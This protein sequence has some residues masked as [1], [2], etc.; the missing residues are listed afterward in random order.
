MTQ[1]RVFIGTYTET[2]PHVAG[3]ASGIHT[4]TY[5][6]GVL[7]VEQ[8]AAVTRNPSWLVPDAGRG[9]LYAINETTDFDDAVG[10]GITAFEVTASGT[11]TE[12][13]RRHSYGSEPCHGGLANDGRHLIVA[14]YRTG[15]VTVF[16]TS[17]NERLSAVP[18]SVMVAHGASHANPVRQAGPHAHAVVTD[19]LTGR[20]WVPDLGQD[21]VICYRL[22]TD[23]VLSEV[24]R[25]NLF[26]GEGPRHIVF[27]PDG[28]HLFVM[29]ELA[30]T[31]AVFRRVHAGPFLRVGATNTLPS[32]FAGHS[33][34]A[35]LRI[36]SSGRTLYATN[37]GHNSVSVL[38][39]D[40]SRLELVQNLPAD[41]LE[42]RELVL[43]PAE[44]FVLL[45]NQDSDEIV[46]RP[47]RQD[48][49]L[50][51]ITSRSRFPT[52]V[53]IAFA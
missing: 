24:D 1:H 21:A 25:I 43:D 4:A 34:A 50:G 28:S 51:E 6:K 52:P 16:D 5:S 35:A 22:S 45:A 48:G 26:A 31:V 12:L 23:G 11:L 2:L 20:V 17:G 46:V 47:R 33:Q 8:T 41:G 39:W 14:N 13:S 44:E 27:H 36:D 40:G 9:L 15:Q 10:G 49:T 38:R 42:P 32:A 30:N 29:N 19:P 3:K 53:C 18:T 37:R 7:G